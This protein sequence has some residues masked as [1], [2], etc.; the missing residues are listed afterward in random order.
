[1]QTKLRRAVVVVALAVSLPA[2]SA[3]S[4]GFNDPTDAAYQPAQGV[5]NR[6]GQ[7]DVLG[8]VVVANSTGGGGVFIAS[9]SNNDQTRSD[10]LTGLS[11]QGAKVAPGT[12]AP[13]INAGDLVNLADPKVG[14]ITI[15]G[16]SVKAGGYVLVR[17]TFEHADPV[18]MKV[19][20]VLDDGSYA[21][22]G[23]SPSPAG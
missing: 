22:L 15:T 7:V 11:A 12:A 20:V 2:L 6:A 18:T 9:F 3:C 4:R 19:P 5:N 17:L 14:G 21:S 1:V 10:K 23:P 8:A 13:T 16:A